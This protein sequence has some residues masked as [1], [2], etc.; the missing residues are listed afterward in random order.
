[1]S[2]PCG[3]PSCVNPVADD[4]LVCAGCAQRLAN[5]LELVV[6]DGDGGLAED[7]DLTLSRQRRTGPGNMGRRSTETPLAYDPTASEAAAVLRNTLSTWCRLLH[8]EIGG[9]LPADTT[10]AMAAWLG[11]FVSWLRRSDFGPECVDEVLAAVAEAQRAVDLPAERVIAGLCEQCGSACYARPGAE[12][13]RCRE[14]DTPLAVRDGRRR[15]LLA[16]GEHLVTAADAARALNTLGHEVTAAAV[17]GYA[18][19]GR[20]TSRGTGSAG[21][22]LYSLGEVIDVY[23]DGVR[24]V[25]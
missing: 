1:M 9:R 11:R 7:L 3:V 19:R 16:A 4:A 22:P 2:I 13:T 25:A 15:L 17:R 8:E 10:P 23:L 18:R 12:H 20:L 5:A 24:P 14:C 6:G 21:R